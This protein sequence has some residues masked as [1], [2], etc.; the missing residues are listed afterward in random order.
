MKQC[1]SALNY[2]HSNKISHRDIKPQNLMLK[3][4]DAVDNV[5]LID[6]GLSQDLSAEEVIMAPAGTPYYMAPEQ[7]QSGYNEKCDLWSI[8]VVLYIMLSGTVPFTGQSNKEIIENLMAGEFSL[9]TP[10]F[11][12]VSS[13]AKD[14]ITNLLAKD[15][16]KRFSS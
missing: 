1:F 3:S 15:P 5:K 6:F 13:Q 16:S 8:G 4:S 14:L 9:K 10:S 11:E 12:N 7:F 2:M